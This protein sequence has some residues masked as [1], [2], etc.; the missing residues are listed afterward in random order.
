MKNI[1]NLLSVFFLFSCESVDWYTTLEENDNAQEILDQLNDPE[2]KKGKIFVFSQ[3]I[4][5][6]VA[7]IRVNDEV[8]LIRRNEILSFEL[9]EGDN[10]IYTYLIAFGD[11]VSNCD[12]EPY[13]FNTK[14]F[15]GYETHY[16]LLL[17]IIEG[18]KLFDCFR[19]V[20]VTEE[21]F[22]YIKENPRSRWK[23]EWLLN[24]YKRS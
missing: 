15:E 11:E 22:H 14:N 3:H 8:F 1:L 13:I 9:K 24:Y 7:K 17:E 6:V 23:Q 20:H 19:D 21:G 2:L 16:F 5:D 10:S 4:D 18:G 12:K